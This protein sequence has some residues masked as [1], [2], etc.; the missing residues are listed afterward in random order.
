VGRREILCARRK[1]QY[2]PSSTPCSPVSLCLR[3]ARSPSANEGEMTASNWQGRY[4]RDSIQARFVCG[5][6]FASLVGSHHRCSLVCSICHGRH[7]AEFALLFG[8]GRARTNR[9]TSRHSG[10]PARTTATGE[11][12]SVGDRDNVTQPR[13]PPVP[14]RFFAATFVGVFFIVIAATPAPSLLGNF[15]AV[16]SLLRN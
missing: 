4:V 13:R 2:R 15:V 16:F 6:N 9:A 10:A 7:A 5:G 11:C 8:L 1:H 12:N 14:A 3:F